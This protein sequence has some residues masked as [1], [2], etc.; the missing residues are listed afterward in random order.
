MNKSSHT[1]SR[2]FRRLLPALL[3]TLAFGLL[4]AGCGESSS[5]YEGSPP[6]DYAS[7][8]A[9]APPPLAA[10]YAQEN[11]LLDGGKDAFNEQM[12]ELK[13]FPVVVNIWASWCG[14]CRAEFPH[15]QDASA[16]LGREVA[17]LGIDSLDD[18]DA[19]ATFLRDNPVPYPSFS[20]PDREIGE[21]L[22]L[23]RGLPATLFFDENGEKT[24]LRQ[25]GYDSLESLKE[26]IQTWA[27]EG[28]QG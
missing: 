28:G 3:A 19:A 2:P 15:F 21:E 11:E 1:P 9:D 14:P 12:A 25:G 17:F 10:L 23:P 22:E 8:L 16:E 4:A 20:D 24:Y 7:K 6:P 5:T 18:A 27:V 13:G 26:D